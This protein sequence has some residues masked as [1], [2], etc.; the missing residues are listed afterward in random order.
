MRVKLEEVCKRIYAGGDVPKDRYSEV[1]TEEYSVPIYANAEK[2]DGLYG[3]TDKAREEELSLTIAARGTIGFTA[4]RREPFLP[5]VRLITVVPDTDKVSE[6][7][8]AQ[9][10]CQNFSKLLTK[11]FG[12][13]FRYL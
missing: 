5:V 4:I 1:K 8:A 7:V 11:L 10:F 2:D 9:N 13:Y 3:Y 6:S 12:K